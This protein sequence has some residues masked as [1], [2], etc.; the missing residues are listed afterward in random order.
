MVNNVSEFLHFS[1]LKY[2]KNTALKCGD[3]QLTY[4]ELN[5]RANALARA[6]CNMG[7]KPGDHIA[8][9]S[10]NSIV[11][12]E[13][14]YG[15]IRAGAVFVPL[16]FRL[17]ITEIIEVLKDSDATWLF[18]EKDLLPETALLEKTVPLLKKYVCIDA[19]GISGAFSYQ[20]LIRNVP[21]AEIEI[22]TSPEDICEIIYTSGTTGKHK[23]V[24]LTHRNIIATMITVML[25]RELTACPVGLVISPMYHVAGLNN[26]LGTTIALGG[27]AVIIRHFEAEALMETIQREKVQFFPATAALFNILVK[28]LE[29]SETIYDTSSIIQ[30][31]SGAAI[32]PADLRKKLLHC[33][34]GARIY[35]AYGLTEVGDGV[36]FLNGKE[37]LEH[38][39]SIGKPGLFARIKV[40]DD[41]H[42]EL[43]VGQVGEIIIQGAVVTAGY[44]RNEAA[45]AEAIRDGWLYTGDLGKYDSQGYL[46]IVGRKK[47]MIISGGENIYPR[48]I[49]E[50]LCRHDDIDDAAVIGIQSEKWGETVCAVVQLKPGRILMESDVTNFCKRYLASYKKPTSV[51]FIDEIPKNA[52]GK[53]QKNLLKQKYGHA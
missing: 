37:S 35:E 51:I 12:P 30:L 47:E 48:E 19:D 46:Y 44:Y 21:G 43:P 29:Q 18:F 33:F 25:G 52:A 23:G 53:I 5:Q 8:I 4:L 45:T 38:M 41:D 11:F 20:D 36:V 26:H 22:K 17:N 13:I 31:Q 24:M 1:A 32:T 49:E 3:Q 14:F 27:T 50:V 16:N 40:V 39:D 28:K 2:P 10:Y 15:I 9:W 7:I 34:C 6:L 42:H